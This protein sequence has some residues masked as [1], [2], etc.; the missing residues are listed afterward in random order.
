MKKLFS[1]LTAIVVFNSVAAFAQEDE[2]KSKEVVVVE[3]VADEAA[4]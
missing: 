4:E 3:T 2:E 1:V